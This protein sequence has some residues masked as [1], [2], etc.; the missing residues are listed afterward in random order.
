MH[1]DSKEYKKF[2]FAK[3]KIKVKCKKRNSSGA[4]RLS[5]HAS[6]FMLV[7]SR[8]DIWHMYL[9]LLL[10]TQLALVDLSYKRRLR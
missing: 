6:C 3:R 5:Y 9:M 10:T 1:E 7:R 4:L 8:Y 2:C